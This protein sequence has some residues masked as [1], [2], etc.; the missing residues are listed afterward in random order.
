MTGALGSKAA[1]KTS[2]NAVPTI[3]HFQP[4]RLVN[5]VSRPAFRLFAFIVQSDPSVV[6]LLERH[7][8]RHVLYNMRHGRPSAR[9]GE[10]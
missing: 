7:R 2:K 4:E 8:T 5:S 9:E 1:M 3:V 10:G 6:L